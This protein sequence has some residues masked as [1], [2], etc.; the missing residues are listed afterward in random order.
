MQQQIINPAPSDSTFFTR[1]DNLELQLLPSSSLYEQSTRNNQTSLKLSIGNGIGF[2][3]DKMKMKMKRI[4][5]T[6][7][8]FGEE[9]RQV[10]K[11]QIESAELEFANAKRIRK[12]AQAELERAKALREE[13]TKKISATILEITCHSCKQRFQTTAA[14][15]NNAVT[16]DEMSSAVTEGE[17]D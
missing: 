2:E 16:A 11:R 14:S 4:L 7:K 10:A 9:S 6:E 15:N 8:E 5:S 13:A 1:N 12:Q 3:E 17:G